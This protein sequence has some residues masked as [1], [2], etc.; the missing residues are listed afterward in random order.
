MCLCVYKRVQMPTETRGIK[1]PGAGSGAKSHCEVTDVGFG[2]WTWVLC[3][4]NVVILNENGPHRLMG[5]GIIGGVASS[6]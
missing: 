5:S 2:D 3:K 6:D 1:S 4:S